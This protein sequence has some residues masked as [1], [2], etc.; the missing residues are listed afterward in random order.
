MSAG[1]AASAMPSRGTTGPETGQIQVKTISPNLLDEL[2]RS[3]APRAA[4]LTPANAAKSVEPKLALDEKAFRWLHNEDAMATGKLA[5][6]IRLFAIDGKKL[7][8]LVA[9]AI[10]G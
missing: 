1:S 5:E 6:G 10:A 4:A 2:A 7:D 8:D 3:A 9:K